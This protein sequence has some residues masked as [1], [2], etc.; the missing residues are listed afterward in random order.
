MLKA[1]WNAT[2]VSTAVTKYPDYIH[3]RNDRGKTKIK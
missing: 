2:P 1:G 3:K